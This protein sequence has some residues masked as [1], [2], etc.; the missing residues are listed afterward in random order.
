[1]DQTRQTQRPPISSR[2][3]KR[4]FLTEISDNYHL[5]F[6]CHVIHTV[7][8]CCALVFGVEEEKP[9]IFIDKMIVCNKREENVLSSLGGLGRI[10]KQGHAL[11]SIE[12]IFTFKIKSK[13]NCF[14]CSYF[15]TWSAFCVQ[16]EM[17]LFL[18]FLEGC[19]HAFQKLLKFSFIFPAKTKYF[20]NIIAAVSFVRLCK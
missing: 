6:L 12:G 10:G 19:K 13:R 1:M 14:V 3:K 15:W 8:H 7:G 4:P 16:T 2:L 11:F 20:V 9:S 17:S 18:S 5:T